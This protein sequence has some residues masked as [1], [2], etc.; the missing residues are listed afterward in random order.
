LRWA[1]TRPG[2]SAA[3]MEPASGGGLRIRAT[4]GFTARP[5][6]PGSGEDSQPVA[7]QGS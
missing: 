4:P 3:F 6:P 1:S 2:V 7:E 5:A